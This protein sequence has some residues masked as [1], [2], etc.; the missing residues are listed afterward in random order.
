M[1]APDTEAQFRRW[2]E[3]L[4]EHVIPDTAGHGPDTAGVAQYLHGLVESPRGGQ[5]RAM[6]TEL[7]A[8]MTRAG[9]PDT[10]TFPK[11]ARHDREAILETLAE[12]KDARFRACWVSFI[13]FCL[14]GY[15]C[16][17]ARGGNRNEAGW[18]Q[19][20]MRGPEMPRFNG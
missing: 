19:V 20:G 4:A 1:S 14:E 11:L 10:A 16:D 15:L 2:L 8:A 5:L 12:S 13:E 9:L 3:C 7:Q 6:V 17:P 18:R